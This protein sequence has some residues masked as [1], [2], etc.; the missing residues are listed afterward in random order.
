MIAAPGLVSC[1]VPGTAFPKDVEFQM[2]GLPPDGGGYRFPKRTREG[3][4]QKV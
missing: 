2:P 4:R 1:V 3:R